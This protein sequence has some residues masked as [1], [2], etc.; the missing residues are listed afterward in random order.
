[1]TDSLNQS[2]GASDSA[3]WLPPS[4]NQYCQYAQEWTQVKYRWGLA[5]DANEKR[6]VGGI[7]TYDC[8]NPTVLVPAVAI[9]AADADTD[10]GPLFKN[11]Y[12]G[13][14]YKLVNGAPVPISYNEWRDV[15]GFQA[16]QAT[17]TDYVK[18]PWSATVYAVTFWTNDEAS[19]QWTPITY[20]QYLT[21]GSPTP[22]I[23]GWIKGSYYYK[24][25]TS[26]E[27]FVEGADGVNHKLT[28]PEWAASG[29]RPFVDRANEGVL[30]LSWAPELTWMTNIGAGWGSA[31][32]YPRWQE[33]AFPTPQT[34]QRIN[35]DQFYQ[36]YGSTTIWYAGPGMNR[37]VSYNE[38]V[39]A[40]SPRPTMQGTPPA[41]PTTPQPPAPPT[42]PGNPGNTKDCGDFRTQAE[43]QRWYNTYF[44]YYG[45]VAQLD[46]NN[47]GIACNGLP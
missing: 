39:G 35:G 5:V 38:W 46:G 18:Y 40:G 20:N 44:P 24:W 11:S 45:D 12:D 30:K 10:P 43:A 1:M 47:D 34:V 26:P 22:R 14:I 6:Y 25:G 33:E 13:T 28:G 9:E 19:W 27:L 16:P 23:A 32:S 8:R 2:K 42:Q 15:Y 17:P 29:Y 41:P 4:F 37:P 7:L 3:E 21:A 36:N 31:L